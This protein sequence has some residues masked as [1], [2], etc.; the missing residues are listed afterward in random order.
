M[1]AAV[2]RQGHACLGLLKEQQEATLLSSSGVGGRGERVGGGM[3]VG[4]CEPGDSVSLLSV[5][6][7]LGSSELSQ[8]CDCFSGT[9][10]RH[11]KAG[12]KEAGDTL[13]WFS[14]PAANLSMQQATV[15]HLLDAKGRRVPGFSGDNAEPSL[16]L[17]ATQRP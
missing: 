6:K 12:T 11:L 8:L 16:A 9:G 7:V 15:E 5:N 2:L 14:G 1:R 13:S 17:G 3:W 4:P 10:A